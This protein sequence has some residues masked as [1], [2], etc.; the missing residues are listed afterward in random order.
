[1]TRFPSHL[2][3]RRHGLFSWRLSVS[4]PGAFLKRSAFPQPTWVFTR[5]LTHTLTFMFC[6]RLFSP[7]IPTPPRVMTASTR[8]PQQTQ[9]RSQTQINPCNSDVTKKIIFEKRK[10]S[11]VDTL[12]KRERNIVYT[13]C[14]HVS[15][16]ND[17]PKGSRL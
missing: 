1:M 3:G 17:L 7:S 9:P 14:E 16:G 5:A 4:P 12:R 8:T 2:L 11:H 13:A 10:N 6:L 15:G